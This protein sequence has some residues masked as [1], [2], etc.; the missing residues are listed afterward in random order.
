LARDIALAVAGGEAIA[1]ECGG[2]S[3]DFFLFGGELKIH[4]SFSL[5]FFVAAISKRLLKITLEVEEL[6]KGLKIGPHIG[7]PFIALAGVDRCASSNKRA[8][9]FGERGGRGVKSSDRME[10]NDEAE[11]KERFPRKMGRLS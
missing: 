7:A 8:V 4:D 11:L 9:G 2:R 5:I 3:D 1:S 6:R 10:V